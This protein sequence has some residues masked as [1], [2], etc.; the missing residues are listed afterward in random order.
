VLREATQADCEMVLAWRNHPQVR[1][2]SFTT[3]EIGL[4]EH[5]AWWNT[6]LT[7]PRRHVLIFEWQ[8]GP[9]GVITIDE[10]D[11][12]T[13]PVWGFYLDIA[14]LEAAGGL[15][16]AWME[17]ERSAV[18]YAFGE[19]GLASIGGETLASN[20]PVLQLHRRFG[21]TEARR[22]ERAVD[23]VPR[24]VVWTEMTAAGWRTRRQKNERR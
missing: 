17:L 2:V 24:E 13:G 1:A 4:D 21:F 3:H 6:V 16:P 22:Y 18:E 7:D 11:A 15:L 14:G 8:G 19:L 20:V 5:R 23:G 10:R 12:Q 9:A